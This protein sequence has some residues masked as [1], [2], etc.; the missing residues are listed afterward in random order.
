MS[1]AARTSSKTS[2][3]SKAAGPGMTSTRDIARAAVRARLA[4]VAFDLF[5]REGFDR[6]TVNEVSAAAGVSRSTF[7]RYFTS[8][9]DAILSSFDAQDELAEQ[10][11]LA[12][13]A[14]Q[15]DWTALQ[16][17]MSTTL[18]PFRRAQREFLPLARLVENTPALT[19]GRREK[20][21][22]WRDALA[23]A[24]AAR[25]GGSASE[26]PPLPALVRAAAAVECMNI[27]VAQWARSDG[28]AG[29]DDLLDAAFAALREG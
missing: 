10:A 20:Q 26:A 11:L 4:E 15:D 12:C 1:E 25:A 8:K 9:E 18:E 21:V 6:V 19:A 2:G 14:D 23:R 29:L 27:A 22:V 24:L 7:L 28:N 3:P 5:R 17:A 13:P 16:H